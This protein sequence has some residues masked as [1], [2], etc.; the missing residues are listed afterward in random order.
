MAWSNN[1]HKELAGAGRW[2][3][4]FKSGVKLTPV[5]LGGGGVSLGK[6][7]HW[8]VNDQIREKRKGKPYDLGGV[9]MS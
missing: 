5:L 6:M 1:G 8:R 9:N 7:V 2:P 4:P 3:T